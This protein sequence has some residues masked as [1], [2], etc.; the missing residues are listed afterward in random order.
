MRATSILLRVTS[1]TR[2]NGRALAEK[3]KEM[4]GCDNA[5]LMAVVSSFMNSSCVVDC[6]MNFS[7]A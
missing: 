2:T 7:L 3:S 5:L 4:T 6:A 1:R